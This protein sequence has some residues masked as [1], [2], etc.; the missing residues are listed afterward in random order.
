MAS[1]QN[2]GFRFRSFLSRF[3]DRFTVRIESE[4]ERCKELFGGVYAAEVLARIV[5]ES[6]LLPS[7]KSRFDTELSKLDIEE[8]VLVH[9]VSLNFSDKVLS[10][11]CSSFSEFNA[12]INGE[13]EDNET[14]DFKED[15]IDSKSVFSK[16]KNVVDKIVTA[17]SYTPFES[18][19][20]KYGQME[21]EWINQ[22]MLAKVNDKNS[23]LL[24]TGISEVGTRAQ[25]SKVLNQIL[26]NDLVI[27]SEETLS[28]CISFIG[29]AA[30]D[31][32]LSATSKAWLM[33]L[34]RLNDA[35]KELLKSVAMTNGKPAEEEIELNSPLSL[36]QKIEVLR[37]NLVRFTH[38]TVPL[39]TAKEVK[40]FVKAS[41]S[42]E[43]S[44]ESSSS[45]MLHNPKASKMMVS[46]K[47]GDPKFMNRFLMSPDRYLE[48]RITA[49]INSCGQL[50]EQASL[51]VYKVMMQPIMKSI[52]SIPTSNVWTHVDGGA[53]GTVSAFGAP[54]KYM[55]DISQQ[56]WALPEQ[57]EN[58]ALANAEYV[59][60]CIPDLDILGDEDRN[61]LESTLNLSHATRHSR[62]LVAEDDGGDLDE[63]DQ[64]EEISNRFVRYWLAAVTNG[65]VNSFLLH[66]IQIPSLSGA[67]SN[68]LATDIAG[69]A[70]VVN[71]F[72]DFNDPL[73]L[74]FR[75]AV[76]M[77]IALLEEAVTKPDMS[78]PSLIA[79]QRLVAEKRGIKIDGG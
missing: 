59:R 68:Q 44:S 24:D 11:V 20:E 71:S 54:L 56:I 70:D 65:S 34:D 49:P 64:G 53:D 6:L 33:H 37:Q 7:L 76:S 61:L 51:F 42:F 55:Q 26:E 45:A 35:L 69:I 10:L 74:Q 3:Y 36:L 78:D 47:L 62:V 27:Y 9:E 43:A 32:V 57:L 8:M 23:N 50:S 12:E 25:L 18:Y 63:E 39:Q 28:R 67:G 17:C 19:F 1:M 58:Y 31:A 77:D 73:L 4:I 46:L 13:G 40:D 16:Q 38:E 30:I 60:M 79:V 15:N 22:R 66:L 2:G 21:K 29:A 52:E 41:E 14:L 5:S 72:F 48:D 75:E